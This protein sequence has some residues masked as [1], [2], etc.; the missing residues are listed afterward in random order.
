MLFLSAAIGPVLAA[1]VTITNKGDP[2]DYPTLAVAGFSYK[3]TIRSFLDSDAHSLVV[4]LQDVTGQSSVDLAEHI[5]SNVTRGAYNY[6]FSVRA[7]KSAGLWKLSVWIGV[8]GSIDTFDYSVNVQEV[9]GGF[10]LITRDEM[11][12]VWYQ[13]ADLT[14]TDMLFLK[15]SVENTLLEENWVHADTDGGRAYATFFLSSPG[16]Y[17]VSWNAYVNNSIAKSLSDVNLYIPN[18]NLVDYALGSDILNS[19]TLS[20]YDTGALIYVLSRNPSLPG[21]HYE[22]VADI[23]YGFDKPFYY[24]AETGTFLLQVRP[25]APGYYVPLA[26][27]GFYVLKQHT[28][29]TIASAR[30]KILLT[31]INKTITFALPFVVDSNADP[32]DTRVIIS[33]AMRDRVMEGRITYH[34]TYEDVF[35]I[36]LRVKTFVDS[37]TDQLF[38]L[39]RDFGRE[40]FLGILVSVVI[41]ILSYRYRRFMRSWPGKSRKH[42]RVQIQNSGG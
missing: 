2:D 11:A 13:T 36:R 23:L 42:A 22:R 34:T 38:A 24:P 39:V 41:S 27:I 7:P 1:T 14:N 31:T 5:L 8:P 16:S 40:L 15:T 30:S 28:L 12:S 32:T 17:R 37:V 20:L 26:G 25:R 9:V 19:H 18:M 3:C 33:L 21:W 6:T 4:A 29:E 35:Q 10:D